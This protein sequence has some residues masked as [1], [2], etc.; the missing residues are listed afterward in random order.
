MAS[1]RD[2]ET[3]AERHAIDGGCHRLATSF[4]ATQQH[5]EGEVAF[6]HRLDAIFLGACAAAARLTA[7]HGEV[8]TG[9]ESVFARCQHG[10]F[11]GVIRH[12]RLDDRGNVG[13]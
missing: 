3:T 7:H 8:S 12:D 1:E 6:I 9:T 4:E 10:T 5:V 13:H 2:F 11:D